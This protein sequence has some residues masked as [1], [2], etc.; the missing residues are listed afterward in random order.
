VTPTLLMAID[1]H[2][3]HGR[4]RVPLGARLCVGRHPANGLVLAHEGASRHHAVIERDEDG[5]VVRDLGSKNG[6]SV[7]GRPVVGACRVRPGQVLS[8]GGGPG[9][10]LVLAEETRAPTSPPTWTAAEA[11][12]RLCLREE[13]GVALVWTDRLLTVGRDPSNTVV[14]DHARVSGHH[15]VIELSG[16]RWCLRDLGSRNGTTVD[17]RR[18]EGWCELGQGS[19]VQFGGG[20]HWVVTWASGPAGRTAPARTEA[21]P[22]PPELHLTLAW[23]GEDGLIQVEHGAQSWTEPAGQTF[24]LLWELAATPGAWVEDEALKA[25]LWGASAGRRARTTLHTA[26][27]NARRLFVRHGLPAGLVEKDPTHRGRTRLALP[28]ECV[29]REPTD[30]LGFPTGP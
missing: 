24:L 17:G 13:D 5:W 16:G 19:R 1:G 25:A 14:V 12:A 20:S 7:D 3:A 9:W 27:Y 15:A 21:D 29:R 26:I 28:A 22:L 18:V 10:R 8:F 6:T 11:P 30:N 23:D 4:D 2:D